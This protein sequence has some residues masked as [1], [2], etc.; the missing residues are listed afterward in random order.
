MQ[1]IYTGYE[2]QYLIVPLKQNVLFHVCVVQ[3]FDDVCLLPITKM[4]D[5]SCAII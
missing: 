4:G 5:N 1:Y 3:V 2:P